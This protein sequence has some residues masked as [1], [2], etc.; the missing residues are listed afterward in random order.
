LYLEID[1]VD[2]AEPLLERLLVIRREKPSPD[3]TGLAEVLDALGLQYTLQRKGGAETLFRQAMEI[4]T[5]HG[6]QRTP[7]FAN[8]MTPPR[9]SLSGDGPLRRSVFAR[10]EIF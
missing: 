6:Q 1:R 5:M 3:G 7:Q 8:V 4:L 10:E 2:E 9:L